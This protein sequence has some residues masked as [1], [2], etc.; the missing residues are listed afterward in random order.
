MGRQKTEA[1]KDSTQRERPRVRPTT[2]NKTLRWLYYEPNSSADYSGMNGQ[3]QAVRN[4]HLNVWKAQVVAW[5]KG[6]PNYMLHRPARHHFRRNRVIVGG[7]DSQW[8]ADLVDMQSVAK[9]NDGFRYLLT[10]IDIFSKY[11]WVIPI[12]TKTGTPLI[13]AFKTIFATERQPLYLRSYGEW[14]SL[15]DTMPWVDFHEG[16]PDLQMFQPS[17]KTV[18]VVDDIM[19]EAEESV[20]ALFTKGS[21]HRNVCVVYLAQNLFHKGKDHRTISLNAQYF[22]LFKNPQDVSQI[23]HIAKQMYPGHTAFVRERVLRTRPR[24]L[25]GIY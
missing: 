2:L 3:W 8:Q 17:V 23:N 9:H 16:L 12:R 20:T 7:I 13:D 15:Y 1:S 25:T 6:Q 19:V 24:N 11:A 4:R 14:Q 18:V 22:V 10:C 21:H 5:L